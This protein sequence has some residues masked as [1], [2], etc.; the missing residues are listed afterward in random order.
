MKYRNPTLTVYLII[1]TGKGI[2]LIKRKNPPH[3]WALLG[4]FVNY[5]ES[6]EDAAI[7]EALEETSLNVKLSKQY[8]AY[9][10]LNRDTRSHIITMVFS[11]VAKGT[12][13]GKDDALEAKVFAL[14]EIPFG[15]LVFDHAQILKDFIKNKY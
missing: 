3:G 6:L 10:D 1:R 5:G 13:V 11:A 4:V 2:V 7:R 12:P 8:H 15:K 9:F 14:D